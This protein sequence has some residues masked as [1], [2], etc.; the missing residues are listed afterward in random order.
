MAFTEFCTHAFAD[1]LLKAACDG[2]KSPKS[3]VRYTLACRLRSYPTSTT[4]TVDSAITYSSG[5]AGGSAPFARAETKITS[6]NRPTDRTRE[7][8]YATRCIAPPFDLAVYPLAISFVLPP[9]CRG[10]A[11]QPL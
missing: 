3:N 1:L 8:K 11:G 9:L 4:A 5:F 2:T 7:P 6:A 10:L